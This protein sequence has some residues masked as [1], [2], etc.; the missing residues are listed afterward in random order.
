VVAVREKKP[1][2][3]LSGH[4]REKL[5]DS[6]SNDRSEVRGLREIG[7]SQVFDYVIASAKGEEMRKKFTSSALK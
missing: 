5:D 7:P 6:L 4:A 3:L 1:K 2:I